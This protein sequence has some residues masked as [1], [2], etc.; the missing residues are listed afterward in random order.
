MRPR[1]QHILNVAVP[2]IVI[3]AMLAIGLELVPADIAR[4]RGQSGIVAAGLFV[5]VLSLP[6]LALSLIAVFDPPA[7]IESGLL[8]IAA[9]PVGGISNTYSY[10][11][12]ASVALSVTLTVVS[13][14]LAVATVPMLSEFFEAVRGVPLGFSAPLP[15]ILGQLLMMLALPVTAGMALRRRWPAA[16]AR[17]H[18]P[19]RRGVFVAM[20]MLL[21]LVIGADVSTFV[22]SL[23]VAVPLAASFVVVSFAIGWATGLALRAAP[24]DRFTLASEFATRNV[25][26]ATAIA[27]TLS[28]RVEFAIF[29]SAYFVTELPMMLGAIAIYR[30][31]QARASH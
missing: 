3:F 30:K 1:V 29:G 12:R 17:W 31:S 24:A 7:A 25:A 15:L 27:V 19:L 2:A 18:A 26:V 8:L 21:A 28:G 22:S 20:A 14:L 5:P 13:S 4:M 9:C 10:L 23:P 6:V 16:A 11:A